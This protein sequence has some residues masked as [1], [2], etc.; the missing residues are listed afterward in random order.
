MDYPSLKQIREE[1][2][3]TQAKMAQIL[4]YSVTHYGECERGNRQLPER[5]QYLA[6]FL[7]LTSR[8]CTALQDMLERGI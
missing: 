3:W 2:G 7:Y 6:Q 1:L 8:L 4:G 5:V